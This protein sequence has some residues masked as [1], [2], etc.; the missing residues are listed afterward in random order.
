M[1]G[2]NSR[3]LGA[4]IERRYGR[5]NGIKYL[6]R[7][8][9]LTL[10]FKDIYSIDSNAGIEKYFSTCWSRIAGDNK[11]H[12]QSAVFYTALRLSTL[13]NFTLRDIEKLVEVLASVLIL[14]KAQ[15][16]NS[17][18]VLTAL[19]A[20]KIDSP[21][22][23]AA[24]Q[25]GKLTLAEFLEWSEIT[26]SADRHTRRIVEHFRALLSDPFDETDRETLSEIIPYGNRS[27]VIPAMVN[28]VIEAYSPEW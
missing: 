3:A 21:D 27:R 2:L 22:L 8:F 26:D 7:F 15:Q 9:N 10:K 25:K 5:I 1:I 17:E 11:F 4:M 13:K 18:I 20:M 24:A 28:N 19:C 23:Y 16:S 14:S 6:S 12:K